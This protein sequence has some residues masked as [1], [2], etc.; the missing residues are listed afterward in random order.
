VES[1]GIFDRLQRLSEGGE[2][3]QVLDVLIEHLQA[4]G[5]YHELFEALKMKLRFGLGLPAAQAQQEPPLDEETEVKLE[6]G[7]IDACRRVGELFWSAGKIREGWMYMRPVGDRDL[8]ASLLASIEPTDDNY[9]DLISVLLHEAVDVRRGYQ[10]ALQRLG[11]CNCIT[12]FD[13][14]L[15]MRPRADQQAAADLLV[16]HVH[17]EL[18]A[19]LRRDIERREGK[20]PESSSVAE[21]LEQRPDLL[22]DGT[23]HLDTSHLASTVRFARVLDDPETLQLALD[24]AT[25]GKRLHPQY[26]YPGDEPFLDQYPAAIAFFRAL[27]GQ[28]VDAGIRYFTQKADSVD[29]Q[30]FGLL[31]VEVLIDLLARCGRIEQAI[32]ETE[33][34]IQM[35]ARTM[36]IAPTL[37]H[38]SQQLGDYGP[39]Q[40]ICRQRQDIL[41]Y[42]AALLRT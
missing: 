1:G 16:R 26:Q 6:R 38:L 20:V 3:A 21:I 34:R 30:Q 33:R 27:L 35:G 7:L 22:R 10:I 42:T 5:Q 15:A 24:I 4:D 41:G 17:G 8:A 36:G 13:Q 31:A 9:D 29:Q 28:Q 2:R 40:K 39:M 18:I 14:A 12:L 25:Y 32:A 19:N 23:Y 11:T 37:L